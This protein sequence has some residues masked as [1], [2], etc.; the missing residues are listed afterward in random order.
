MQAGRAVL[1]SETLKFHSCVACDCA[2]ERLCIYVY[3]HERLWDCVCG[4][5]VCARKTRQFISSLKPTP[6]QLLGFRVV[7]FELYSDMYQ[8]L[9]APK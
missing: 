7:K 1:K 9:F 5:R 2:R 8:Y 3:L 6:F 4:A